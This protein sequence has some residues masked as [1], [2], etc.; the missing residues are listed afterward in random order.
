MHD[1]AVPP[2][3]PI[4]IPLKAMPGL[5]EGPAFMGWPA[6]MLSHKKALTVLSDGNPTIQHGHDIGYVIPHFAIPMNALCAIN[7]MLSKHKVTFPV[8]HVKVEHKPAG[9]YLFFLLGEI[10]ASP[11]SLPT[12]VVILLKCTVQTS[13]TF[14]DLLVGFAIIA[15]DV[16]FDLVWNK[17]KGYLPK[18]PGQKHLEVLGGLGLGEM[19][20]VGG[21]R[22]IAGYLLR[23]GTN[24]VVQH[25]AKSWILSP[26]VTGLP[27]GK[28]GVGRGNWAYYPFLGYK[29]PQPSDADH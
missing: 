16:L 19:L 26:L 5:I 23:E 28:S 21:G 18:L 6:G 14:A 9:T 29:K 1:Q 24:K 10:C 4:P 22:L 3:P 12:G 20:S 11:V 2:V 17:I 8:S 25:I 27:F 7:T 13:M 15:I